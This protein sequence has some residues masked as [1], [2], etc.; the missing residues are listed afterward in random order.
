MTSMC[1]TLFSISDFSEH[2][3]S[4]SVSGQQSMVVLDANENMFKIRVADI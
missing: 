1:T 3:V 2:F 4:D